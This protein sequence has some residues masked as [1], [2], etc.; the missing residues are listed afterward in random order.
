MRRSFLFVTLLCLMSA[1][2]LLADGFSLPIDK[3]A[4]Q[5]PRWATN[6]SVV[7]E[8]SDGGPCLKIY[9]PKRDY[10]MQI[11]LPVFYDADIARVVF[12][13]RMKTKN[14]T[15]GAA[16]I[17]KCRAQL[18]FLNNDGDRLGNWPQTTDRG[19]STYF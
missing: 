19:G 18:L 12:T 13:G 7:N 16:A 11:R 14:V 8:G 5:L 3:S 6:V 15:G 1:T 10:S 4:W 9:T 2:S 17:E